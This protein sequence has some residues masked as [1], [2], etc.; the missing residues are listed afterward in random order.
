MMSGVGVNKPP[1][2]ILVW[3]DANSSSVEVIT[4]ENVM[5]YHV[6]ETMNTVGWLLRDDEIG[7]SVANETYYETGKPRWRGHT[8]VPRALVLDVIPVKLTTPRKK[9]IKS[10]EGVK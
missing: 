6:P 7:V 1:F 2:V 3:N 5:Q 8:F 10:V 9:K 4:E